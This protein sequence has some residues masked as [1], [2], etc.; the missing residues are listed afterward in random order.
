M[1]TT[2][3]TQI[4]LHKIKCDEENET[5]QDSLLLRAVEQVFAMKCS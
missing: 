5:R 1:T 2:T 4:L 3:A